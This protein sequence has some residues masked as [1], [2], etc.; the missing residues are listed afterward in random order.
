MLVL[1][2]RVFGYVAR[3][4]ALP[5]DGVLSEFAA[6]S[7]FLAGGR[8]AVIG[9]AIPLCRWPFPRLCGFPTPSRA[10]NVKLPVHPF[11]EFH[12][13]PESATTRLV[14]RPKS[15]NNSHGLSLPT[16]HDRF[17]SP[18]ITGAADAR[19]G[20][21]SGFGYPLD[22]LLLPSPCRFYFAP[23]ALL[24]F[25]LRSF[26]LSKGTRSFPGGWTH[27]P[28]NPSL[29]PIPDCSEAGPAQQA[30]ASGLSPF[31]ESLTPDTGLV[32][33]ELDAPLGFPLLGFSGYGL[34]PGSRPALL[35]RASRVKTLQP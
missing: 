17:G 8:T 6:R 7:K 13:P 1:P 25:A 30:A 24:G 20:P 14:H 32:R 12:V 33:Q 19:Y 34:V 22:G 9:F 29:L 26:L 35:P 10:G 3:R 5:P 4:H 28:F 2:F 11:F 27:V 18:L 21:P 16:A 23:A 31:R 15:V